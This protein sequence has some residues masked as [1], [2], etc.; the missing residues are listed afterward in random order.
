MNN[1]AIFNSVQ[2]L[3]KLCESGVFCVVYKVLP[4]CRL[5]PDDSV[6]QVMLRHGMDAQASEVV[7]SLLH[8]AAEK[9]EF[10][11]VALYLEAGFADANAKDADGNKTPLMA[12]LRKG[13]TE[14]G[15]CAG[16]PPKI[17]SKLLEYGANAHLRD[18]NGATA[19]H[20][21]ARHECDVIVP[22]LLEYG[23]DPNA[24]DEDGY[25]HVVARLLNDHR[26]CV[27]LN[28]M[29]TQGGDLSVKNAA[30]ITPMDL[31]LERV[32]SR[33]D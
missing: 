17:V 6:A 25:V 20:L 3:E 21:A 31:L 26:H 11:H 1:C 22:L 24:P 32:W 28:A 23:A 14:L 7:C 27:K 30:L 29:V 33:V 19:L 8:V 5:S 12:A 4:Y 13:P 15:E 2:V 9:G 16:N 18:A 10:E